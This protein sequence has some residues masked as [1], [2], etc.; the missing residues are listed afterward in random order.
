M[1]LNR[2]EIFRI[3]LPGETIGSLVLIPATPNRPW[4]LSQHDVTIAAVALPPEAN[5]TA[6]FHELQAQLAPQGLDITACGACAHWLAP[7]APAGGAGHCTWKRVGRLTNDICAQTALAAPC[8][9][10]TPAGQAAAPSPVT[11]APPTPAAQPTPAPGRTS[12]WQRWFSRPAVQTSGDEPVERIA[13]RS[14]KRPGA[15]PCLACPGRMANLGAQ[16]CRT[17]EGDER[18]FSIWRCRTCLAYFLN[19]W[20]D[21]WVRT[22][23]LEVVDIYY[24]LAPQEALVCLMQVDVTRAERQTTAA[25]QSWFESFLALRS[26]ARREVRHGR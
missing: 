4:L 25:M 5:F 17:G 7:A 12:F 6:I 9:Q 18:T 14:G 26:P 3:A 21:K 15:I 8:Q 20:T 24:R 22:D 10:F 13:E 19:D 1:P 16:R 11:A 23:S 2:T